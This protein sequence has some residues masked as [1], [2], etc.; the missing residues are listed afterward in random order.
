MLMGDHH[1]EFFRFP[2]NISVGAPVS[3]NNPYW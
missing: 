2:L 1:A 3:M